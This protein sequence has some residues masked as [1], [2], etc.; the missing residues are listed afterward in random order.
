MERIA[1]ESKPHQSLWNAIN[2]AEVKL[3]SGF[4]LKIAICS[5]RS[6]VA[7]L[8]HCVGRKWYQVVFFWWGQGTKGS[9]SDSF[10][11]PWTWRKFLFS[12]SALSGNVQLINEPQK[13]DMSVS[14]HAVSNRPQS[15]RA[16]DE[17][18]FLKPWLC[19]STY[20]RL[21]ALLFV[22]ALIPQGMKMR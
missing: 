9:Y 18:I 7:S 1:G 4:V 16:V 2:Q 22:K 19:S 20:L 6:A 12:L 11:M 3:H 8:I 5:Q 17:D 14:R 15:S 21:I 10:S 13:E